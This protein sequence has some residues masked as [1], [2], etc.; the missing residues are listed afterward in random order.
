MLS[1]LQDKLQSSQKFIQTY[2][3]NPI[4]V[5]FATL[6]FYYRGVLYGALVVEHVQ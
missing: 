3:Q 6:A 4:F 5:V 2:S 1:S